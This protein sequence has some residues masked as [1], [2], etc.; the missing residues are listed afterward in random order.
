MIP[1]IALYCSVTDGFVL[2]AWLYAREVLRGDHTNQLFTV[3]V[4]C[5]VVAIVLDALIAVYGALMWQQSMRYA[6]SLKYGAWSKEEL[7]KKKQEEQRS[8]YD[9][10]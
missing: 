1:L 8:F 3:T 10:Y 7:T 9:T 6:E 5:I 2:L 4:A